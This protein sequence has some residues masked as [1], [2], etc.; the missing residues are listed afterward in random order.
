MASITPLVSFQSNLAFLK[1][2]P[3]EYKAASGR[4]EVDIIGG[5]EDIKKEVITESYKSQYEFTMALQELVSLLQ[6]NMIWLTVFITPRRFEEQG[7][8]ISH[9]VQP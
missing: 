8:A 5:L 2:P 7:T 6:M 4:G 9:S 1:A 3:A